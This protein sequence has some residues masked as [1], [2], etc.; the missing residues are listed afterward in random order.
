M[1]TSILPTVG[2]YVRITAGGD[3]VGGGEVLDVEPY[4][5]ITV[6]Q[7]YAH[8]QNGVIVERGTT[9][10]RFQVI[11]HEFEVIIVNTHSVARD[12]GR[13]V[14]CTCGVEYSR[15]ANLMRHIAAQDA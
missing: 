4:G 1:T 14:Q 10:T 6:A 13:N 8:H 15:V 11:T 9:P 2:Q 5:S 12:T 7:P 3:V